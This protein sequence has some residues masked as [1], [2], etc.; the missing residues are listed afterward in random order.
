M[1]TISGWY[2]GGTPP[3]LFWQ[4]HDSVMVTGL[5][6]D[7]CVKQLALTGY[8]FESGSPNRLCLGYFH[9]MAG[10]TICLPAA[11]GDRRV[12]LAPTAAPA[13]ASFTSR[14]T[15]SI[16]PAET[17]QVLPASLLRADAPQAPEASAVI[18]FHDSDHYRLGLP[19]SNGY[20]VWLYFT[21]SDSKRATCEI[22]RWLK[23]SSSMTKARM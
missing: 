16:R 15:E 23:N 20:P 8:P 3:P 7:K 18:L 21:C 4:V 5:N 12:C 9:L 6:D 10:A 22:A 17:E 1:T 19:E 14:T 13:L 2:P 11:P